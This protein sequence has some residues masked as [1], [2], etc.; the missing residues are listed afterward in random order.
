M[1]VWERKG[2]KVEEVSFDGDLH[3]FKIIKDNEVLATITPDSIGVM[4]VIIED[5][6]AGED[7]NG[8]DDGMGN[9]IA[10]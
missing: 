10:V 1:K 3:A 7:V 4:N 5:L 6:D 2:Y 8:W 9:T